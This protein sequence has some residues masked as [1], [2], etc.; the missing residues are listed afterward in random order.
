MVDKFSWLQGFSP[1][2]DKLEV[3]GAPYG[4][5][6]RPKPMRTAL[7]LAFAAA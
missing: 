4:D 5:D 3:R 1:R 2:S 6:Y 7:A